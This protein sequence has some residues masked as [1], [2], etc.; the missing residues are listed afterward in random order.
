M[1]KARSMPEVGLMQTPKPTENSD[2]FSFRQGRS[3]SFKFLFQPKRDRFAAAPWFLS[4][5]VEESR[6]ETTSVHEGPCSVVCLR[7]EMFGFSIMW[8]PKECVLPLAGK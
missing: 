5:D 1:N 3:I 8:R 2:G 6:Q 4:C 7:A